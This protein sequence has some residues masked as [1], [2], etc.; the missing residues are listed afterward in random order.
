[1]KSSLRANRSAWDQRLLYPRVLQTLAGGHTRIELLGRMLAHP[2][3]LAPVAFQRL[4]HPDG[5]LASAYAAAA[6]G[7]GLV[8]STQASMPLETVAKA[9]LGEAKRSAAP[10][11][12][13]STS[14]MTGASPAN[15]CS[16]PKAPATRPWC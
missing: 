4:A 14:S 9:F 8:L 2:I 10:C 11:G 13:S 7:A 1:M 12:F 15:W 16:V 5:E 6:Q 3:L